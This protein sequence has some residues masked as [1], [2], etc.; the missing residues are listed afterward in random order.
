MESFPPQ[1]AGQPAPA[2]GRPAQAYAAAPAQMNAAP[3]PALPAPRFRAQAPY[4]P[5][6][7]ELA[8]PA[9]RAAIAIPSPE[10]LGVTAPALPA[11]DYNWS[12]ANQRLDLLGVTSSYRE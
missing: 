7:N 3:R 6:S 4:E 1:F 9:R 8:A 11:G 12:A 10:Q 5:V 2:F